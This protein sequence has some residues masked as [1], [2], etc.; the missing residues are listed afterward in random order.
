MSQEQ[1]HQAQRST[2]LRLIWIRGDFW[3]SPGVTCLP[4]HGGTALLR[5]LEASSRQGLT[6]LKTLL[7]LQEAQRH[8][9]VNAGGRKINPLMG[10]YTEIDGILSKKHSFFLSI[11]PRI[12]TMKLFSGSS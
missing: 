2:R 1:E 10:K 9:R 8:F 12:M 7:L 5:V 3:K 11:L 4:F 6:S